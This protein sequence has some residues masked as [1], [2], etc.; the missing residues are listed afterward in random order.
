NVLYVTF[1]HPILKVVGIEVVLE[2]WRD[3]EPVVAGEEYL[4]LDEAQFVPHFGTWVK[5]QVDFV[6]ARRIVFTGSAT[7]LLQA[8]QESGVGRWHT[9][10]ISTLSFYEYLQIRN[11]ALPSIPAAMELR[12][13][14]HAPSGLLFRVGEAVQ[15]LAGHFHTYLAR[16]GFETVCINLYIS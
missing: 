2:A 10:S 8:N 13:F 3:L 12:H 7:P 14:L 6:K 9:L 11:T 1:D 4:F 16:G 5:H 15:A